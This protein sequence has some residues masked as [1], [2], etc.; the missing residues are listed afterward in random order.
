VAA[1]G[2]NQINDI[3]VVHS[4]ASMNNRYEANLLFAA[5]GQPAKIRYEYSGGNST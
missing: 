1:A 5:N 4:L 2:A 3:D